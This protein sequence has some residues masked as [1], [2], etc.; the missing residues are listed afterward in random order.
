M[1][2]TKISTRRY[3]RLLTALYLREKGFQ[4]S[5]FKTLTTYIDKIPNYLSEYISLPDSIQHKI[6]SF[7]TTTLQKLHINHQELIISINKIS[8]NR[9]WEKFTPLDQALLLIGSHE[10]QETST[11]SIIIKEI[12]IV[13]DLLNNQNAAPYLSGILKTLAYGN[14]IPSLKKTGK[15]RLKNPQ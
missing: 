12:L 3:G 15:I 8:K 1:D 9:S 14:N 7:A 4:D 6:I 2:Y 5:E 13:S 10:L 11:H